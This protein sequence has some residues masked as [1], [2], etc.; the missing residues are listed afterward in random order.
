[1]NAASIVRLVLSAILIAVATAGN[2]RA[3][4][5]AVLV[6]LTSV[7]GAGLSTLKQTPGV[8]W[9]IEA[10]EVMLLAGDLGA[11]RAALPARQVL[12]ELGAVDPDE[13]ALH[14]RGCGDRSARI[15]PGALLVPGASYDLVRRPRAFSPV[16]ATAPAA[17]AAHLGAPEWQPVAPN[18]TIARQH[19]LDRPEGALPADPGIT[20]IADRV[21]GARWFATV[22]SL[23]SFDRS[24]WS[25]ELVPARQFIA[26]QFAGL[27]LTVSEPVFNFPP[28]GTPLPIA[29]V[30]GRLEGSEFP[31]QW[32]VVGGHYDSRNINNNAG[33]AADTPGA[34]DNAS[35]CSGVI[36]AARAIAPF[37]PRRSIVFMCY[38]GEEQGLHGSTGHVN[39]L[40]GAGQ[41]GQVR[42]ML[43]MDMIGWSAD[44]GLGVILGTRIDV[45]T[46]ADNQA[47]VDL[48]GDAGLTYAP[49][50]NPAFIQ[51]TTNTCCSDH[52]PYINAGRPGLMS[53]HRGSAGAY[54]HYHRSS[55]TPAN[56]GPFA[57]AI[58]TAI[59]RMNVA[60]L[61]RLSGAS[62]RI[63][64]DGHQGAEAA[65]PLPL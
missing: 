18:T 38:A 19:R 13:L 42:A 11:I 64:A 40:T 52:M 30:I 35:G 39:A 56:L 26:G 58:G 41:L 33:G 65:P 6:D 25:A 10:G 23:A 20:P 34:D 17:I 14:A 54:P 36:E 51:K 60:A 27:G 32:I 15:A 16:P 5:Q 46:P 12:M 3:R 9:W 22:S 63:F 7:D 48:V 45:G 43:N 1:V 2:A 50:L 62:D 59:V 57:E 4:D 61:A 55:D 44:A 29:N 31:D 49:A 28:G 8:A 21:D 53:I 47:L 24:S 37:K